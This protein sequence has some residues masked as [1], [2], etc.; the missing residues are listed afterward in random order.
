MTLWPNSAGE[1]GNTSY[2]VV[3]KL[4]DGAVV[5]EIK[6]L[7]VRASESP[8]NIEDVVIENTKILSNF[9]TILLSEGEWQ[10]LTVMK[11]NTVYFVLREV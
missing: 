1:R 3:F 5:S 11:P 7:F 4:V 8:R 6:S 10:A 9:G 2:K